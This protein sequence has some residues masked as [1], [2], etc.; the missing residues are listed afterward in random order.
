[1]NHEFMKNL[2]YVRDRLVELFFWTL[3]LYFEPQYSAARVKGSA[4]AFFAEAKWCHEGY[5]LSTQ[6]YL[7]IGM[8]STSYDTLIIAAL[9]GVGDTVTKKVFDWLNGKLQ[10]IVTCMLICR[11][12][13]DMRSHE[14]ERER[15]HVV[16]V[17]ECCMKEFGVSDEEACF[18]LEKILDKWW[19]DTNEEIL[20]GPAVVPMEVVT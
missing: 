9:L 5:V 10:L 13:D 12:M 14:F 16:S 11:V 7:E 8:H 18:E 6:E 4:R 2:P 3:G 17:V 20:H 1:M 15:I 19:K